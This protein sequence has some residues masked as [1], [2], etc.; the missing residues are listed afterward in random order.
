MLN[1]KL[2]NKSERF[3]Y[4]QATFLLIGCPNI[5]NVYHFLN[6]LAS[7]CLHKVDIHVG[8][9]NF[10]HFIKGIELLLQGC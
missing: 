7:S 10:Q 9:F 4:R 2:G 8:H 5:V 6:H 3:N 1:F